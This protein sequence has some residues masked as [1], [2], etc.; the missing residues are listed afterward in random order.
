M[1]TQDKRFDGGGWMKVRSVAGGFL[2]VM[3][4]PVA[5][6]LADADSAAPQQAATARVEQVQ[7]FHVANSGTDIGPG[8]DE[9]LLAMVPAS[10]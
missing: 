7:S 4:L 3:G 10:R 6:A 5:L 9:A 1:K 8:S 2:L